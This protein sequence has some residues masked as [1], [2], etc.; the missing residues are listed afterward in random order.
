MQG[1]VEVAEI[2]SSEEMRGN[3]R[4]CEVLRAGAISYDFLRF[5]AIL[6]TGNKKRETSCF[7]QNLSFF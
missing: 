5:Y 6:N 2:E 3:A 1:K 7:D 4:V